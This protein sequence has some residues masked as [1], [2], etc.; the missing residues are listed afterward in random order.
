MKYNNKLEKKILLQ[1]LFKFTTWSS[2]VMSIVIIDVKITYFLS[3][4]KSF[5]IPFPNVFNLCVDLTPNMVHLTIFILLL[6]QPKGTWLSKYLKT[7]FQF[8]V[9]SSSFLKGMQ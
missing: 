8:I 4:S 1:T 9:M 3:R 5:T 7:F 6:I 2:L